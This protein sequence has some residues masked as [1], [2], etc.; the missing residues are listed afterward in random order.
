MI[1]PLPSFPL[2]LSPE[3]DLRSAASPAVPIHTPL[4]VSFLHVTLIIVVLVG[5]SPLHGNIQEGD[6]H[7]LYYKCGS[8]QNFQ[9]K[10]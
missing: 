7:R 9:R 10:R 8:K 3:I 5:V 6:V 4:F 2:S 1:R